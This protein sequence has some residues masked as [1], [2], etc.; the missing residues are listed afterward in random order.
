MRFLEIKFIHNVVAQLKILNLVW[1]S[2]LTHH[3]S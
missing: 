2:I 3:F 1:N